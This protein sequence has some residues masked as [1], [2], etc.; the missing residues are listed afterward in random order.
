MMKR[1]AQTAL[2][3]DIS[4]TFISLALVKSDDNGLQLI[5]ASRLPVPQNAI[6][7]AN[8]KDPSVLS[9]AVLTLLN[10]NKIKSTNVAVSLLA[11]PMLLQIVDMPEPVPENIGRFVEKEVEQCVALSGRSTVSDFYGIGSRNTLGTKRLLIAAADINTVT[12]LLN[13]CRKAAINVKVIEPQL[14]AYA[15]AIHAKK[16]APNLD[17]NILIATLRDGTFALGVFRKNVLDFVRTISLDMNSANAEQLCH[18][19]A[20]EI[21]TITRFYD[22]EFT[23]N[24]GKWEI[25]IADDTDLLPRNAAQTLKAII[26]RQDRLHQGSDIQL[27][28]SKNTLDDVAIEHEDFTP[29]E[30]PSATAIGLAMGLLTQHKEKLNINLIPS[31]VIQARS[32]KN[33][34]LITANIAAAFIF[35]MVMIGAVFAMIAIK[36]NV[37]IAH[38]KLKQPQQDISILVQRNKHLEKQ[39]K[40]LS[41]QYDRLNELSS[42]NRDIDWSG[43]LENIKNSAPNTICITNLSCFDNTI[44]S[45]EG[46]ALSYDATNTFVNVLENSQQIASAS[47]IKAGKD[48]KYQELIRYEISCALNP[49]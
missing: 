16:I 26:N 49:K 23:N 47:L 38:A 39:I 37:N 25:N 45:I 40:Q 20:E 34:I 18:Q 35:I 7:N 2:G 1:R 8:I 5:K 31:K 11:N 4:E 24:S 27:T 42:S 48:S 43:I 33:Q 36:L 9:K 22:L 29:E 17:S 10:Q 44:M 6:E 30:Q 41:K 21:S 19:L 15:R 32:L 28:V 12:E 46:L 3:I 13:T 14:L